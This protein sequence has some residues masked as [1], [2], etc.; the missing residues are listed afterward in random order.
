[1]PVWTTRSGPWP[2]RTTRLSAVGQPFLGDLLEEGGDLGLERAGEHPAGSFPGDLGE[3]ILDRSGL[4]QG[5]E[6]G[7]VF[8]GVSLRSEGLAGWTHATVRHPLNPPSPGIRA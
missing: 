3:R 1:M 2:Y 7:A 4:A 8:H 5:D 6:A